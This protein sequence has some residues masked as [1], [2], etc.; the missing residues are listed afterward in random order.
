M[1]NK[2]RNCFRRLHCARNILHV[3]LFVS[4]LT[5]SIIS[6]IKESFW[7]LSVGFPK[8]VIIQDYNINKVTMNPNV[9]VSC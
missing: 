4:F 6:L 2:F 1:K 5:F 7:V 9:T 3:S 8:D